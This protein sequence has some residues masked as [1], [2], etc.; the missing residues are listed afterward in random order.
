L[1]LLKLI[2]EPPLTPCPGQLGRLSVPVLL[3]FASANFLEAP[4]ARQLGE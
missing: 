1:Y 4:S 2:P 3:A